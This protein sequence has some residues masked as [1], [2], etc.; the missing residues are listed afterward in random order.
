M[1]A[2][3]HLTMLGCLGAVWG[4]LGEQNRWNLGATSDDKLGVVSQLPPSD[5]DTVELGR[6]MIVC[7]T[8]RELR[9]VADS[10]GVGSTIDWAGGAPTAVPQIVRQCEQYSGISALIAT[11]CELRPLV[12]WQEAIVSGT[13]ATDP[14]P[15][16]SLTHT[17]P[18]GSEQPVKTATLRLP[19]DPYPSSHGAIDR[20]C[21]EPSA[22][23]KARTLGTG[24]AAPDP[25]AGETP[26]RIELRIPIAI[27]AMVLVSAVLA[28]FAGR[29]TGPAV[30]TG[31]SAAGSSIM[32]PRVGH[33]GPAALAKTMVE[34]SLGNVAQACD[35]P[36]APAVNGL[37]LVRALDRCG[38]DG[39]YRRRTR[40][41]S[42]SVEALQTPVEAQMLPVPIRAAAGSVPRVGSRSGAATGDGACVT[43][44]ETTHRAC[45][46]RCGP[47]P[48]EAGRYDAYH[49]CLGH[50]LAGSSRCRLG[51]Q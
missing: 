21:A 27:A 2:W 5:Y 50:C 32:T 8:V 39:P 37:A 47:E 49:R 16:G 24:T 34:T 44:C 43:G 29:A 18:A 11:L 41:T 9:A 12:E 1:R 45:D 26:L 10:L 33:A 40:S 19:A 17:T 4:R 23:T 25:H 20:S 38:A 14:K 6:R 42:S 30:A 13:L 36:T 15:S 7:F 46:A 28:F 48:T 31:R 51:C 35:L 22:A 3:W